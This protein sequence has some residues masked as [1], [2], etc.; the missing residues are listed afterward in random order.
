MKNLP[1]VL[2]RKVIDI[3]TTSAFLSNGIEF[4]LGVFFSLG[5]QISGDAGQL[6]RT[7]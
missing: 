1:V 5:E 6:N 4:L 7:A 2:H 3:L